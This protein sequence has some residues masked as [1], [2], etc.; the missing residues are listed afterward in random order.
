[1]ALYMAFQHLV[2]VGELKN[3]PMTDT[4]AAISCGI[5]N[6]TPVLDLDYD[7]DSDADTDANFVITGT[8]GMCEIQGTAE[9]EPFSE[10]EFFQ[11]LNQAKQ[12]CSALTMLQKQALGL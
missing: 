7:E 11:M 6:G 4:I 3:V 8:G 12:G 2:K 5:Y 10:E 9:K 1:M